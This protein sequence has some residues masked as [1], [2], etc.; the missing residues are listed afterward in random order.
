MAHADAATRD[1][2][3]RHYPGWSDSMAVALTVTLELK[4][5][6]D[7]GI[8]DGNRTDDLT[9]VVEEAFLAVMNRTPNKPPLVAER[10]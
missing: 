10:G 7:L 5:R 1:F 8:Y 3:D 9:A 4:R 6:A 2:M